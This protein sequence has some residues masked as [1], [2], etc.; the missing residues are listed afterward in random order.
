MKEQYTD[1]WDPGTY[2]CAKC[3]TALFTSDTKFKSGTNW[4]SFRK[5]M[6]KAVAT[7]P[8]YTHGM[9]RTEVICAHCS[10]HLGHVFTDGRLCGDTHPEAG[11][12]YCVLSD[13]L[14]F[15]PAKSDPDAKTP[16][17]DQSDPENS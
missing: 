1:F 3:G 12:R 14:S 7:Q 10:E 15:D 2:R 8:D 17:A 16:S 6:P 5:A 11:M 13:A 4:P 9:I